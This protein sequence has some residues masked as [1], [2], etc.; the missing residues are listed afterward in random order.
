MKEV[1]WYPGIFFLVKKKN[2]MKCKKAVGNGHRRS[3]AIARSL[4]G[5]LTGTE[6]SACPAALRTQH[7]PSRVLII[8]DAIEVQTHAFEG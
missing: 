2:A 5:V 8:T 3:D 4:P 7:L 1:L 6:T